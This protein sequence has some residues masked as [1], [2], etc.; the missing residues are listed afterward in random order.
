MGV[1]EPDANITIGKRSIWAS[2]KSTE[3]AVSIGRY[4][5][6][7]VA[8]EDGE[9]VLNGWHFFNNGNFQFRDGPC[10]NINVLVDDL[11]GPYGFMCYMK[12]QQHQKLS[13]K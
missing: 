3:N 9:V 12:A 11:Y 8:T 2:P 4:P 7:D 13:K 10:L 6:C 1:R 5:T